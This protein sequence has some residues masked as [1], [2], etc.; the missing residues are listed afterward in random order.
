MPPPPAPQQYGTKLSL[1]CTQ[2]SASHLPLP[3]SRSIFIPFLLSARIYRHIFAAE[4]PGRPYGPRPFPAFCNCPLLTVPLFLSYKISPEMQCKDSLFLYNS[5]FMKRIQTFL[6]SF[7][8]K[9]M[10]FTFRHL[11][12]V[13]FPV[14]TR[15]HRMPLS[16]WGRGFSHIKNRLY[17]MPLCC[18]P[19]AEKGCATGSFPK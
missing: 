17:G 5:V 12:P 9:A 6:F 18:R 3:V 2:Y 14:I 16:K 19:T 8:I 13:R 4:E 11:L 10:F 7:Y 1:V 15:N